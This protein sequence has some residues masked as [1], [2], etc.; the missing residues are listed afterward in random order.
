MPVLSKLPPRRG[1][2]AQGGWGRGGH[3]MI[4]AI[5]TAIG[6]GVVVSFVLYCAAWAVFWALEEEQEG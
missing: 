3:P 4:R 6:G 1:G 2:F 5:E